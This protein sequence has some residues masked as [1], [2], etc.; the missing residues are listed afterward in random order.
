MQTKHQ[1]TAVA[2]LAFL[3][4]KKKH[5]KEHFNCSRIRLVGIFT[6]TFARKLVVVVVLKR[7]VIFKRKIQSVENRI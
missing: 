2:E 1:K 7:K 4:N 3:F 5:N 6:E